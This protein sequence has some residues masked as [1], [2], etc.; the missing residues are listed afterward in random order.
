MGLY[1]PGKAT[2][3]QALLYN[4]VPVRFSDTEIAS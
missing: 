4:S 2:Y 1:L 3:I